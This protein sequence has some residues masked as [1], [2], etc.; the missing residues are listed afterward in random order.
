MSRVRDERGDTLIEIV[1]AAML[2]ALVIA[3][4]TA[5]FVSGN[6]VSLAAQRQAELISVADQ[7]IEN[8]RQQVK[9]Q[10]FSSLAM[11]ALPA[12]GSS[13]T[14]SYSSKTDVDP[15]HFAVAA[16][17]CGLSN[18]GYTIETN[19]DNT[20]EG[21]ASIPAESG[22]G[23]GVEPLLAQS[24]GFVTPQQTNVTVGSGTATVDSYVTDTNVG[25]NT[26]LG[27]GLC[28]NDARRVIVAVTFNNAG[29]YDIGGTSPVYVSTIFTNPTPTNAP[30]SSAGLT[31]GVQLG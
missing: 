14:L 10:G 21:T 18:E 11:S 17:G 6:D 16:S 12:T 19:Y 15:N 22:C 27:S 8:I 13:A 23:T 30:N 29:R 4:A 20:S 1:V 2:A 26:T 31:L 3:A 28:T 7:Q 24:G 9:T 5:L 25:C